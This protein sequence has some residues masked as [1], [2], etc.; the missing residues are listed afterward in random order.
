[1]QVPVEDKAIEYNCQEDI[2]DNAEDEWEK[3][4]GE[5]EDHEDR[6]KSVIDA[7]NEQR[8]RGGSIEEGDPNTD[9]PCADLSIDSS[10]EDEG[11]TLRGLSITDHWPKLTFYCKVDFY[12]PSD[13]FS[14]RQA[15]ANEEGLQNFGSHES[16]CNIKE[17]RIAYDIIQSEQFN[18][19]LTITGPVVITIAKQLSFNEDEDVSDD[20]IQDLWSA[21]KGLLS[22]N[23]ETVGKWDTD[24]IVNDCGLQ[25]KNILEQLRRKNG[26][27]GRFRIHH[28]KKDELHHH[29]FMDTTDYEFDTDYLKNRFE[30]KKAEL[31]ILTNKEGLEEEFESSV[32]KS[33]REKNQFRL[34]YNLLLYALYWSA[35]IED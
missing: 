28:D 2:N 7:V 27:H 18:K 23:T 14:E 20:E 1:M 21:L 22:D 4:M 32:E 31:D 13:S 12:S 29:R 16:I 9:I 25:D 8:A 34:C 3:F 10:P 15:K 11:E 6:T 35:S 26:K 24:F 33:M 19:Y 30:L 5:G 17:K